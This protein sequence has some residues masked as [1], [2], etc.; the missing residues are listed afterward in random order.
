VVK[1][2]IFRQIDDAKPTT[3][4][5]AFNAVPVEHLS[6]AQGAMYGARLHAFDDG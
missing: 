2:G 4:Q 5:Y 6:W 3:P 1:V